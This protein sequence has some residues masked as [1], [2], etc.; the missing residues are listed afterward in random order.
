[1]TTVLLVAGLGPGAGGTPPG[2]DKVD[3]KSQSDEASDPA[4]HPQSKAQGK[5]D[6]P[7]GQSN[8]TSSAYEAQSNAKNSADAA[9]SNKGNVVVRGKRIK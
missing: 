3:P 4:P 8:A 2:A 6:P 1:M 9:Q 5:V 7:K